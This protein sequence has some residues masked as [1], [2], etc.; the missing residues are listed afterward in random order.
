MPEEKYVYRSDS[1]GVIYTALE[2]L[3]E[4]QREFRRS[5]IDVYRESGERDVIWMQYRTGFDPVAVGFDDI[6]KEIPP[7][8]SRA[9]NRSYLKPKRTRSGDK[10]QSILNRMN[11]RPRIKDTLHPFGIHE[12]NFHNG[13]V[14]TPGMFSDPENRVIYFIC[15]APLVSDFLTE[16]KMSEFWAA[17][18]AYEAREE[19]KK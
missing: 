15:S 2:T 11:M 16:I 13:R 14:C 5:V 17:R 1:D 12:L 3:T 10:W 19:A 18:E 4:L 8:L 9:Q 7:G 6:T